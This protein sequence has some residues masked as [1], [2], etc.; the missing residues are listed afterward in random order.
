MGTKKSN[1]VSF[2]WKNTSGNK[3]FLGIPTSNTKNYIDIVGICLTLP[4]PDL[5]KYSCHNE[6]LIS[7]ITPIHRHQ[8]KKILHK[9]IESA[10]DLLYSDDY[11]ESIIGNSNEDS[12]IED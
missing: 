11:Q 9:A 10:L 6:G 1:V 7:D 12:A 4:K 2:Q 3:I 8:A 5:I